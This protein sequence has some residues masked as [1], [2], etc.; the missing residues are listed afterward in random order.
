MKYVYF[1]IT[2]AMLVIQPVAAKNQLFT[3][4]SSQPDEETLSSFSHVSIHSKHLYSV[5]TLD[6]DALATLQKGDALLLNLPNESIESQVIKVVKGASG[7]RHVIVRSYVEGLPVSSVITLGETAV[8]LEL[9]TS[10]G[11]LS[12]LGSDAGVVLSNPSEVFH[13]KGFTQDDFI[14]A[15]TFS[16]AKHM[17]L[18]QSVISSQ[19]GHGSIAQSEQS[20]TSH[21]EDVIMQ[22]VSTENGDIAYIDVLF[23]YSN[24]V[25]DVIDDI[26]TTIDH[27]IAYTNQAF[28]DSGIFAEV[29]FKG[30]IAVDYDYANGSDALDDIT[31]GNAPF[32]DIEVH[33]Y[34]LGADAV[35]LLT[36]NL[37][38][39]SS[40]GIAFQNAHIAYSS[41]NRMYSQSDV[42]SSA[43]TFAHELG[44]NLGLG[45]SRP[46]GETRIRL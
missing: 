35:A 33:R 34:Q 20:S 23:V 32:E 38:G 28:E 24:N 3:A 15:P 36:P 16:N 25:T 8:R 18:P 40:A 41:I 6:I 10:S 7:S 14:D 30:S 12:G 46:Q 26:H 19:Q 29:R 9:V 39:D 13:A 17:A 22:A 5:A 2:L 1:A 37:T 44:H 31:Y 21:D 11:T 45:H 42:D 43:S 4:Y 27:F